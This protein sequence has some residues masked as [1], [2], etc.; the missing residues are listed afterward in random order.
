MNEDEHADPARE[1]VTEFVPYALASDRLKSL[2][3]ECGSRLE[4]VTVEQDGMTLHVSRPAG[5]DAQAERAEFAQH[6]GG[7]PRPLENRELSRNCAN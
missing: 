4:S 1:I 2:L 7:P 6:P 3:M 5:G